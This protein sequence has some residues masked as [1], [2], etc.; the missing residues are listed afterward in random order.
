MKA[1]GDAKTAAD[2]ETAAEVQAAAYAKA[3]A[4]ELI[5]PSPL[6]ILAPA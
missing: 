1:A 5:S 2:A 3:E 4:D 6:R